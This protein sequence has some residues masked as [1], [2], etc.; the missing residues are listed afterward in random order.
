VHFLVVV[1]LHAINEQSFNRFVSGGEGV[2]DLLYLYVQWIV[3]FDLIDQT[4]DDGFIWQLFLEGAEHAIPNDQPAAKVF[5]QAE[6]VASCCA[7]R[8]SFEIE[9]FFQVG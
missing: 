6:L 5:V 3:G 8:D 1:D 7:G 9:F 2:N 4:V